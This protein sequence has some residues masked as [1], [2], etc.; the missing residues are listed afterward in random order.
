MNTIEICNYLE[1]KNLC[2]FF[3][4]LIVENLKKSDPTTRTEIIVI[5]TRNFFVVKGV[6]SSTEVLNIT[7]V[8]TEGYKR[9][10]Q[11][12]NGVL[13][14]IDI[15][16]Y[17][18]SFDHK[19]L[20]VNLSFSYDDLSDDKNFVDFHAK[21][22][23]LFNIK[24]TPLI[25]T[26]LFDCGENDVLTVKTLLD[27]K[28]PQYNTYK[29][30]F[31]NEIYISERYYGLS[32]DNEKPYHILVKNISKH[33]FR[34]HISKKVGLSIFSN[35]K[36]EDIDNLN[37]NFKIKAQKSIVRKE[38][39]RSLVLDLFPFSEKEIIDQYNLSTY[40][41]ELEIIPSDVT[42]LPFNKMNKISEFLLI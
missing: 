19:P 24:K 40:N 26:I 8:L 25:N 30:D 4:N 39:L 13:S 10:N 21:E 34:T 28:Y 9:I 37:V 2:N 29:S 32:M 41:C 7:D 20:S 17:N 1:G 22:G 15:I 16:K 3:A 35:Q 36:L 27:K 11:K 18:H 23:L 33:I 5:N 14:V 12:W 42:E 38:W 31:S 6:T